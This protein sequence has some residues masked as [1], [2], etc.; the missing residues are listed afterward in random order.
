MLADFLRFKMIW[1]SL[2]ETIIWG[3]KFC[4]GVWTLVK[5]G[6]LDVI[7]YESS[8]CKPTH[9]VLKIL[10]DLYAMQS[11]SSFFYT[12]DQNILVEI[13]LRNLLDLPS[14][15]DLRTTYLQLLHQVVKNSN[16]SED[17][18][19]SA[20]TPFFNR[21]RNSV[22]RSSPKWF[23]LDGDVHIILKP[24]HVKRRAFD[25]FSYWKNILNWKFGF[26]LVIFKFRN[27]KFNLKNNFVN[28]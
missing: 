1:S 2:F 19:K 28:N 8:S 15:S 21:V 25:F 6:V 16:W 24:R 26:L 4:T 27:S 20:Q 5:N 7:Y 3:V 11:T 10:Q 9:S 12:S 18:H 13:I 14:D 23:F 17:R 22:Q